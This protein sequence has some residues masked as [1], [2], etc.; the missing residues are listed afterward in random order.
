MKKML[1]LA[2]MFAALSYASPAFADTNVTVYG[3]LDAA[4]GYVNHQLSVDPQFPGSVN[5]VS[6]VSAKRYLLL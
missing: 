5:P 4:A 1:S 2:A 3:T 6:P